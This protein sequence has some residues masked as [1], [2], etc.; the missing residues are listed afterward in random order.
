MKG[1][2]EFD[3]GLDL[4]A[5]ECDN[6]GAERPGD[7]CANG[8]QRVHAAFGVPSNGDGMEVMLQN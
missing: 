7:D 2:R 1:L 6:Q 4:Q 3:C 5:G 8:I